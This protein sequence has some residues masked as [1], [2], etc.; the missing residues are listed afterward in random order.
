ML[1]WLSWDCGDY[2]HISLLLILFGLSLVEL[3]PL[4]WERDAPS[5]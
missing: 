1:G 5:I 3:G 4:F 2:E